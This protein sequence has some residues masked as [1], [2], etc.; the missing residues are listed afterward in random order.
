MPK[1]KSVQLGWKKKKA[2]REVNALPGSDTQTD[3]RDHRRTL[4]CIVTELFPLARGP[5]LTFP[6]SI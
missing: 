5:N 2:I 1:E 3:Q 6:E 4:K